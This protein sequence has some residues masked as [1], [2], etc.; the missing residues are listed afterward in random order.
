MA[1]NSAVRSSD[2]I[3]GVGETE[4]NPACQSTHLA[5]PVDKRSAAI[6]PAGWAIVP[7]KKVGGAISGVV[8][9]ELVEELKEVGTT[10]GFGRDSKV[11]LI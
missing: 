3:V 9:P 8:G 7:K 10:L 2:I 1:F 11:I 5:N 4:R 6:F